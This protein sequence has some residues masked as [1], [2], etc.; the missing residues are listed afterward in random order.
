MRKSNKRIVTSLFFF[1]GALGCVIYF[2]KNLSFS[3]YNTRPGKII[4]EYFKNT[5]QEEITLLSSEFYREKDDYIWK[6][7]CKDHNNLEFYV[8]YEHP[9]ETSGN[10]MYLFFDKSIQEIGVYDYYWQAKLQEK[11]GELF[12]LQEFM[13][14]PDK[15]GP[16]LLKYSFVATS[17]EDVYKLSDII[18]TLFEYT[19]ENVNQPSKDVFACNI[20]YQNDSII[21]LGITDAIYDYVGQERE[22][23]FQYIYNRIDMAWPVK[24]VIKEEELKDYPDSII[25]MESPD[26]I[27]GWQIIGD[28]NGYFE[29]SQRRDIA[30]TGEKLPRAYSDYKSIKY[31]SFLC[32]VEKEEIVRVENAEVDSYR[33]VEWY[34][35]GIFRRNYYTDWVAFSHYMTKRDLET[36]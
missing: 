2:Y 18:T 7:K 23:I 12:E 9:Y 16:L 34:P 31:N 22:E 8:Y 10:G 32:V 4:E 19:F 14:N 21:T 27:T 29:K 11:Y 17:E 36:Y 1:V 28:G 3:I 15:E 30:L 25:V 5:Y 24:Y 26:S 6:Y 20:K 13:R 35:F 33:I